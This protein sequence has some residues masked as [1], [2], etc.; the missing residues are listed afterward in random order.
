MRLG[1]SHGYSRDS[2]H[3]FR[4][5]RVREAA[6]FT[7][8]IR[9]RNRQQM[10]LTNF[11]PTANIFIEWFQPQPRLFQLRSCRTGKGRVFQARVIRKYLVTI[12][13]MG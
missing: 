8:R 7:S 13:R 9:R 4:L 1:E 2:S 12:H 11:T 3:Y 5:S 6:D 10:T